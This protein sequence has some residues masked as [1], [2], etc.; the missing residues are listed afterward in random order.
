MGF[1]S[2]ID[3]FVFPPRQAFRFGSL[4]FITNDF[5]KI[6][7]LDSGPNL[8]RK[9][10]VSAPFGLPNSAEIYPKIISSESTSNHSDEIPSTPT[11]PDQD[12][13]AYPLIL[14]KLPD[15]LAVVFTTR[16]SSPRRS[17]RDLVSALI[18][19]SFREV[20]IIL[21]PLG[22]VS[23]EEL[24]GYLSSPGVDSRPTEILKYDD[25]GY[26]YDYSNLNDFDEGYEDNYTPSEQRQAREAEEQRTR[27]EAERR[28]LEEE[29]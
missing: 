20:G 29:R 4:D 10:Q 23:T 22:T 12:D 19:S 17:R 11:R 27:L 1:I 25:F 18:Q 15:D 16:M 6:C 26:R 7:L 28:R 13:R 2:G 8:S 3:D 5:G 9:D 21:Q 14:M 24:D